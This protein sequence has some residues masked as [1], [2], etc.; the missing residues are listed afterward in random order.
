MRFG[1][2]VI[3]RND[4]IMPLIIDP[5]P[6]SS[7]FPANTLY[8]KSLEYIIS[9]S[10]KPVLTTTDSDGYFV[11]PPT[12]FPRVSLS[13]FM[14]SDSLTVTA[15]TP[16]WLWIDIFVT[17]T[18]GAP[19]PA[20]V[21][22]GWRFYFGKDSANSSGV[23]GGRSAVVYLADTDN[24][25]YDSSTGHLSGYLSFDS[26]VSTT[27]TSAANGSVSSSDFLC[28][29]FVGSNV[30]VYQYRVSPLIFCIEKSLFTPPGSGGGEDPVEPDP[31]TFEEQVLK[32][33]DD[34]KINQGA[35]QGAITAAG[36]EVSD[37]IK[38]QT[39]TMLS[40][41]EETGLIGKIVK[42]L[43]RLF[44]PSEDYFPSLIERLNQ[45]FSDRFGF[46]YYPIE[47]VIDFIGRAMALEDKPPTI[48]IPELGW[49]DN[50]L[51]PAQ[52]YTFDFLSSEPWSTIHG[53]Y[54]MAIDVALIMAFVKLLQSTLREV[55][56]R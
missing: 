52:T 12:S 15:N 23:V 14:L 49:E 44:I 27:F 26:G 8:F 4:E 47:L 6:G 33:L 20:S 11:V 53:Y 36:D 21:V 9:A 48:A 28:L 45:F 46:L 32:D 22:S 40:E 19:A 7:A 41:D 51:I 16:F 54:L 3:G 31:P 56:S 43:K 42:W 39:D 34:I 50:V 17:T 38:D 30:S 13:L 55:L 10:N 1:E 35:I 37:A 25:S 18:A 5:P 29:G 2:V 24:F